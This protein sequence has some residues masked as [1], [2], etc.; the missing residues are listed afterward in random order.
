MYFIQSILRR[1]LYI[2]P[3]FRESCE[4]RV[5]KYLPIL[6]R[7]IRRAIFSHLCTNLSAAHQMR[8]VIDA[9]KW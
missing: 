8:E 9:N 5:S 2:F 4:Y 3:I 7:T 1:L 6:L